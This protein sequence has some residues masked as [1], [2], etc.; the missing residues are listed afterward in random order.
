MTVTEEMT[1]N[2]FTFQNPTKIYFGKDQLKHLPTELSNSGKRV[3]LVYGGGSIKKTGL[4]DKLINLLENGKMEVFEL[5][6]IEPNPRHTTVNEGVKLCREKNID[7]VLAVGGGSVIDASKGICATALAETDNVWD[8]VEAKKPIVKALPLYVILTIAATGSEMNGGA[9]ISNLELK[10]KQGISGYSIRPKVSFLDP[11][12]TYSVSKYQTAC[13]SV[14][15]MM[16]TIDTKYF[17]KDEKMDMI[18]R[19]MDEHLLTV[20][21][22]GP[23]ALANPNDYEARANLMWASTWA[24]NSFMTCGV[25]QAVSCHTMEHELSA[26]YDITHGHGLAI[27][28]PRWLEYILNED[29]AK[30][31]RRLGEKCFNV[32]QTLDDIKASKETIAKLKEFFFETLGLASTLKELNINDEKFKE[33]AINACN[34]HGVIKGYVD[35][36]PE[37]VEAI[38]RMCL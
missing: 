12:L 10:L 23:T 20:V 32:D 9:V 3:L 38:Y 35:L 25:V 21:K 5:G 28:A 7:M 29:T 6:G 36:Y 8:L 26:V 31:I 1:M 27:L 22:W 14:D 2:D 24:L 33:M 19:M 11:T 18:Y 30:Q 4:Y 34:P 15:I 13:G 17:S 16:H 37:D